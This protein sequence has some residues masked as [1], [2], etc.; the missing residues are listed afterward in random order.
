MGLELEQWS[1]VKKCTITLS[2][3]PRRTNFVQ[4]PCSWI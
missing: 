2:V 4:W 3:G 1:A